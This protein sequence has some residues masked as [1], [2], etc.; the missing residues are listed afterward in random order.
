V[1]FDPERCYRA[2]LSRDR[3]FDGRFFT[4]VV[5][6]GIYCRP[7]C[8]VVPP[9]FQ[10]MRF[11]A[12]AAAAEAAGFRPC[13]R[14]RPETA[15]G[16]P[17]W[18]GTSAVVSRGLRL[19]AEGGLDDGDLDALAAR[20][21]LG[22][23]QLRRLF[24][25][26][27]GASPFD[28]ARARRVHFARSLI[29]QTDLAFAEIAHAAGFGSIRQFNH[30][31]KATFG[32]PPG[33]LRGRRTRKSDGEG[34]VAKRR[35]A[36]NSGDATDVVVSNGA[37]IV[38]KLP[39]RP[40]LAWKAMLAF[41]AQRAIPGVESVE[42][43]AYRRTVEVDGSIGTIE[44]TLGAAAPA[45]TSSSSASARERARRAA[46][47]HHAAHLVMRVDVPRCHNLIG[48]VERA[49]R[50]FD[51]GADPT[52]IGEQ[53]RRDPS[54][55][56]LVAALPGLRVPGAWD[57]F[58]LAVRGVLG[59]QITVQGATTLAGRLVRAFGSEREHPDGALTH[60]FPT[61]AVMAEA[62]LATIGMPR[63]RAAALRN[64]AAAVRDGKLRFDAALGLD[65]A[66]ERICA[67]PGFGPWTAHY[68]AM[69]ALGEPD[70]FPET[71]IGIRRALGSAAA[72]APVAA[73]R[74]QAEHW[75]PWRSYAVIY[76]WNSLS[77]QV[78]SE[79]E[80]VEEA[81]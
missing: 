62:D 7:V 2:V 21:G 63:A 73:V 14:C 59:Q 61:P 28:V 51:L 24:A 20:L 44:V 12:C 38:V 15:P 64:L 6:T 35:A 49:R 32:E 34:T 60:A 79:A 75:R 9:K 65:E 13:K 69:R 19:I 71:D 55:A 70:A 33:V 39:F 17:A 30:A 74:D 50:L 76:L 78:T 53:L 68:I 27:L 54:L 58:E 47:P 25:Q 40:P 48:V 5:T 16:T 3:R 52:R 26:H 56:P 8:P 46:A 45:V 72:L 31:L 11:Y 23:R 57:G 36:K 66:V 10:N 43:G 67:I 22:E 18:L 29:D 41:L 81:S 42:N 4:G 1:E 77:G 37:G 80:L